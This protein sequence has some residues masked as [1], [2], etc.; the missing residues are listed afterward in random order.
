MCEQ[1]LKEAN[2]LPEKPAPIQIDRFIES[3]FKC[4][5]DYGTDLG[6]GVM[7]FTFF[8]KNGAPIVVGVSPSLC[9]EIKVNDRRLRTTLAHEAGHCLI[10]PILFMP[11]AE[12]QSLIGTNIDL[13]NKRILCRQR[14]FEARA[15]DGRWWEVQANAAIGGYL[16][17]KCLFRIAVEPFL[18][19]VG[20]M[21]LREVP[22]GSR[23]Q[24]ARSIAEIFDVNPRVVTIRLDHL[25]P[26][27]QQPEL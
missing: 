6:E 12:T 25:F 5:L 7:G 19:P 22:P 1:A 2:F 3:H 20:S 8:S 18:K 13:Q 17:P 10:H 24:I 16:L 21:G 23:D 11:D 15:Y 9:D 26:V 4:Q 27:S 14:D